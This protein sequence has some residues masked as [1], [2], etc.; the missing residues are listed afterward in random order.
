MATID[1]RGAFDSIKH[2]CIW[3][4]LEKMNVGSGLINHLKVLYREAVFSIMEQLQIGFP[5]KE[6]HDRVTLL[7]ATFS[8]L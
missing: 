5:L 6:V 1:F 8:S 4:T 7:Q 2:D 3:K